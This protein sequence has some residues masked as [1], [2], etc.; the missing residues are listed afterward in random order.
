MRIG[1]E[2]SLS[3]SRNNWDDQ[4]EP[5]LQLA[6]VSADPRQTWCASELQASPSAGAQADTGGNASNL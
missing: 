3:L 4:L 6:V 1:L 2:P 5:G